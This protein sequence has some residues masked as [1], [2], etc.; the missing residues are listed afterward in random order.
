MGTN[1]HEYKKTGA[2]LQRPVH[3]P[4]EASVLISV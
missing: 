3:D 4:R 2:M 1:E